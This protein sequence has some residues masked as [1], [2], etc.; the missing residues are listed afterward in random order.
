MI[1]IEMPD[2]SLLRHYPEAPTLAVLDAA[3]VAA[4][5][6]L[7]EEHP[8]ADDLPFDPDHDVPPSLVTAH[9]IITRAVELRDLLHLYS[10]AI[11]RAV[12]T[13][14]DIADTLF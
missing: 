7:R 4:E 14:L 9:L 13:H 12:P 3:R 6:A 8:T 11:R 10:A 2:P 5:L 1:T